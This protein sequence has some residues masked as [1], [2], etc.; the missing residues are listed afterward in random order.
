MPPG[1]LVPVSFVLALAKV[2]KSIVSF[3]IG[4]TTL[5]VH[6]DDRSWLRTTLYLERIPD[7][8]SKL[9]ESRD[10]FILPQTFYESIDVV[11]KWSVDERIYVYNDCINSHKP[12]EATTT[13]Q[14]PMPGLRQGVSYSVADLRAIAKYIDQ[15]DDAHN[16][17]TMIY[18]G[19]VRGA[20][21]HQ[22]LEGK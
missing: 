17:L 20:I 4:A 22:P 21:A 3:G 2:K 13:Y 8:V 5:T 15:F 6:F 18:G 12:S 1:L 7:I 16:R 10:V 9:E 14:H 11:A 19:G